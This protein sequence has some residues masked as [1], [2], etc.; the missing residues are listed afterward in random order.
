VESNDAAAQ[1]EGAE[2]KSQL[3]TLATYCRPDQAA[4]LK[5]LPAKLELG[6]TPTIETVQRRLRET[7]DK[8]AESDEK[9]SAATRARRTAL[10]NV[11][12]D[13]YRM[14]PELHAEY[15]PLAVEL[16]T[17]RA[18]EFVRHIQ[19]SP[20]YS[21]LLYAK[22]AKRSFRRH[23]YNSSGKKPAASV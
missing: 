12:E 10:K 7:R 14:W 8:M 19:E 3:T 2:L 11:R 22:N 17:E 16:A 9:L 23:P 4:I 13:L 20:D 21:T 5:Q 6:S 15:A 18:D 1:S